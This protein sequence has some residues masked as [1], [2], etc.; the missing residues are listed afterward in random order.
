MNNL[1]KFY[2]EK[3]SIVLSQTNDI[4]EGDG[5]CFP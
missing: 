3:K 2:E 1:K 5:K 4:V